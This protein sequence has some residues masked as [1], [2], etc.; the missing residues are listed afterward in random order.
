MTITPFTRTN[1]ID[2]AIHH[3]P[4]YRCGIIDTEFFL[5]APGRNALINATPA[6]SSG[7]CSL[8]DMWVN[9]SARSRTY[10]LSND[11]DNYFVNPCR[12]VQCAFDLNLAPPRNDEEI[13]A[14]THRDTFYRLAKGVM[15]GFYLID[16]ETLAIVSGSKGQSPNNPQGDSNDVELERWKKQISGFETLEDDWDGGGAPSPSSVA[17]MRAT[18]LVTIMIQEQCAPTRIAPSVVGGIG[19]TKRIGH[20]KAYIECLN[21]GRMH[22]LFADD[23]TEEM[24][25]KS[26]GTRSFE[27]RSLAREVLAYVTQ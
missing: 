9:Y 1:R 16:D 25:V 26:S 17:R 19:V 18:A 4:S 21:D 2:T 8:S 5:I 14:E 13:I 3:E 23:S 6:S 7:T 15:L 27:M 24:A 11:P 20:R 12:T 10:K 22:V